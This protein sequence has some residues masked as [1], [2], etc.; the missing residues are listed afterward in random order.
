MKDTP[1]YTPAEAAAYCKLRTVKGLRKAATRLGL[2]LPPPRGRWHR[3]VLDR[4]AGGGASKP[5]E[6][7]ST[8]PAPEPERASPRT[9]RARAKQTRAPVTTTAGALERIRQITKGGRRA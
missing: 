5:P 2:P 7:E 3:D 9:H 1:W 6:P 8:E 4:I